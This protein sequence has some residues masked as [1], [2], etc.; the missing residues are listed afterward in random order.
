M[1]TALAQPGPSKRAKSASALD[2]IYGRQ[3]GRR[4]PPKSDFEQAADFA[5]AIADGKVVVASCDCTRWW[6]ARR[7]VGQRCR[8]CDSPMLAER[9][10]VL[11]D[12]RDAG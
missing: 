6:L 11:L 10:W 9:N 1:T 4:L 12:D 7:D 2:L 3:G 8:A 5:H